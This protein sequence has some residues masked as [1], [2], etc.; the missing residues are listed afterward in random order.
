MADNRG[1][2]RVGVLLRRLQRV[3]EDRQFSRGLLGAW[4][5]R[6]P[7]AAAPVLGSDRELEFVKRAARLKPDEHVCRWEGHRSRP[8]S[9]IYWDTGEQQRGVERGQATQATYIGRHVSS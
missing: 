8:W 3:E 1:N 9:A 2:D 7:P 5:E 4:M 6:N